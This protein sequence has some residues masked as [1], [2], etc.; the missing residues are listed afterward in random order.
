MGLLT[1]CL[2]PLIWRILS[3]DL[4][5]RILPRRL[6]IWVLTLLIG[7]LI[8]RICW[9][10]TEKCDQR[11]DAEK[12]ACNDRPSVLCDHEDTHDREEDQCQQAT[13][14]MNIDT[15][16]IITRTP[17]ADPPDTSV[18]KG[19]RLARCAVM[20]MVMLASGAVTSVTFA[21]DAMTPSMTFAEATVTPSTVTATSAVASM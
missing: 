16:P 13:A 5:W 10:A 20:M 18:S 11:E 8:T 19:V 12:S 7:C 6:I 3:L 21:E 2:R 14:W 4:I 9:L 17:E 15:I 1:A